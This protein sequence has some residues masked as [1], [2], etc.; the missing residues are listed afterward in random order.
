MRLSEAKPSSGRRLA[1]MDGLRALACL[2]VLTVHTWQIGPAGRSQFGAAWI[3]IEP[4]AT[5]GLILF[6]TLSGFLLYRPFAAAIAEGRPLPNVRRYLRNRALRIAPAYWCVLLLAA[7]TSTLAQPGNQDVGGGFDNVGTAVLN[8]VLLQSYTPHTNLTGIPP[9]WSM[10]V[11]VVFYLVLPILAG[12]TALIVGGRVRSRR[13]RLALLCGPPVV[14][15]FLGLAGKVIDHRLLGFSTNQASWGYVFQNSFLAKA[16]LFSW[17]ML[18][19]VLTSSTSPPSRRRRSVVGGRGCRLRADRP[20]RSRQPEPAGRLGMRP[21]RRLGHSC[22]CP[23]PAVTSGA[24]PGG[25]GGRVRRGCLLQRVPPPLACGAVAPSPRTPRA[26]LAGRIRQ[27]GDGCDRDGRVWQ[28][29]PT[30]SS[31][32]RRC[33]AR[34]RPTPRQAAA[35]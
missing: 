13:V 31:N 27:S 9:A 18:A 28:R 21:H 30:G 11:E 34:P 32:C 22:V 2:T 15:L 3:Y 33:D 29:S 6:F 35:P 4:V 5:I 17:G 14:L 23:R 24:V 26:R 10:S 7:L 1:G 19:A 12:A 16:D 20:R 8:V 25:A